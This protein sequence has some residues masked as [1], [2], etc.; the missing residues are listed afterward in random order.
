VRRLDC[1]VHPFTT[2]FSIDDVRLTVRTDPHKIQELLSTTFHEGGHGLYEQSIDPSYERTFLSRGAST[3]LHESQSRLWENLVGKSRSLL[4]FYFPVL[5]KLFSPNLQTVRFDS[6]YRA[7]N[8]VLPSLIRVEADELTYNLHVFVRFEIE[9]DLIEGTL[10]IDGII[11]AWN[12]KMWTYLGV[13]VQNDAEGVL[14]DIHWA[15]S[16]FGYFPTYA[17]GNILSVQ[18]FKSA[19]Q[20]IPALLGQLKAGELA[21]L[22]RWLTDNIYVHGMRFLPKTLLKRVTGQGIE[23][24]HYLDYLEEKYGEIYGIDM[25]TRRHAVMPEKTGEVL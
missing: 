23:P 12:E 25:P 22:S 24:M 4:E 17:L 16:N 2:S 8:K 18:F 9:R 10:S 5:Q 14:Q 21:P 6:F 13:E 15:I 7:V 19:N 1:S 20:A 11:N 3:S